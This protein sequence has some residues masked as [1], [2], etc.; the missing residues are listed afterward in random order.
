MSKSTF[1]ILRQCENCAEMFEAQKRTTRFC[2]TKCTSAKYKLRKKLE[3][4]GLVEAETKQRLRPKVKAFDLEVIKQ[5]DFLSVNEV[6]K[7]FSCSKQSI[8][9]MIETNLINAHNLNIKLTRI[10]RK[11]IEQLFETPK[12]KAIPKILTSENC[13]QMNE[14]T[15][16]YNVTRNTIYTY[17]KKHNIERMKLN[18]NTYYSKTDIDNLFNPY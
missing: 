4:K 15:N 18:G 9:R 11:D 13:Y 14:I 5:K 6:A 2:S 17:G 10:R 1:T 7:L 16:K 3:R 8:Y 12:P